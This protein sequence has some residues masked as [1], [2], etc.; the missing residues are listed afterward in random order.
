[1]K[2]N[3]FKMMLA[4]CLTGLIASCSDNEPVDFQDQSTINAASVNLAKLGTVADMTKDPQYIAYVTDFVSFCKSVKDEK[5]VEEIIADDKLTPEEETVIYSALGFADKSAFQRYHLAQQTRY[6]YLNL[7]YGLADMKD[8]E[9]KP[10]FQQTIIDISYPVETTADKCD[11]DFNVC[12]AAVM[13]GALSAQGGCLTIDV[14]TLGAAAILCHG[15]FFIGQI[16][17]HIACQYQYEDCR[18]WD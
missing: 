5:K 13:S 17:G 6:N 10:I 11:R 7:N 12:N 16:V 2:F 18:G 8:D 4:V 14:A 9:I 3:I 1:M 15:G